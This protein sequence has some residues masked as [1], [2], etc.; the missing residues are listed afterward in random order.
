MKMLNF[1][2]LFL[3]IA[4]HY[5]LYPHIIK[6]HFPIV[7]LNGCELELMLKTALQ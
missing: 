3:I 4:S 2:I 7:S 5:V 6:T 1:V